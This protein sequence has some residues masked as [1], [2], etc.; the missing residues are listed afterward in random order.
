[1]VARRTADSLYFRQKRRRRDLAG[2]PGRLDAARSR[3]TTGGSRR[4]VIARF[5]QPDSKK[6]AFSDKDGKVW[7]LTVATKQTQMVVD[8]PN[9][10]IRDYDWSPKGNFLAY[11]MQSPNGLSAIFIWNS[12]DNKNTRVTPVM[13]DSGSPS[14]DPSGNYLYFISDR[15]Y[16]AADL[17]FRIQLRNEPDDADIR[18]GSAQGRK[19][20]VPV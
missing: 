20:S 8:A 2:R 11:S 9:G 18:P 4:S 17:K 16:R 10:L 5:G 7:V 3:S 15:E 1:M 19:T 14:W 13:F 12:A 6:I